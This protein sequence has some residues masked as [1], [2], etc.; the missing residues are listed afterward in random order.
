MR[1]RLPPFRERRNAYLA[2]IGAVILLSLA[3]FGFG[4]YVRHKAEAAARARGFELKIGSVRPAWF[5]AV[6]S[7]VELRPEGVTTVS[8]HI[9][10][11]M[12]DVSPTAA[13]AHGG[14]IAL[15]GPT[16]IDDLLAWRER[17]PPQTGDG[18]GHKTALDADGMEASWTGGELGFEA[19]DIVVR[20]DDEGTHLETIRA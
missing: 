14:K 16:A 10:E 19:H 4:P 9:D 20:R 1:F 6:L 12:V 13:H 15:E 8:I 7:D 2:G 17:R 3:T 5:G 11:V 18:S